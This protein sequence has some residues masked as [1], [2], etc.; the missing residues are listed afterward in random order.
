MDLRPG[1]EDMLFAVEVEAPAAPRDADA[2]ACAVI[3]AICTASV[4]PSVGRRTFGRCLR[5]L[6]AGATARLGFRHPGKADAID[7]IWRER[8]RRFGEYAAS[9]DKLGYL[10]TLP[11]IGPVTRRA[12]ALNLGLTEAG[13]PERRAVA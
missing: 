2:F 12:A 3:L 11:W 1:L 8:H 6:A 7:A 13:E 5:A 10:A 4:T 9:A